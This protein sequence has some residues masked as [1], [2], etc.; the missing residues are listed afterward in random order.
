MSDRDDDTHDRIFDIATAVFE[1]GA[2]IAFIAA[3]ALWSGIR[4]GAI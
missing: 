2:L 1:L 3:V 4:T